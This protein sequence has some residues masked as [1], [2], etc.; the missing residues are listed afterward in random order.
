[1]SHVIDTI[2]ADDKYSFRNRENLPQ[3]I[4]IQLSKKQKDFSQ[5]FAAFL[6]ST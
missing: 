2:T 5:F 6:K 1:M 4:E 3:P